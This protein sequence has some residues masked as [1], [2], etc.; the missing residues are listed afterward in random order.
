MQPDGSIIFS[1][2]PLPLGGTRVPFVLQSSQSQSHPV[3]A[4]LSNTST[5]PQ[6][7][8]YAIAPFY[9]P[10]STSIPSIPAE[11]SYRLPPSHPY[12]NSFAQHL[13]A[14]FT[15]RTVSIGQPLQR[16]VSEP[17]TFESLDT[18]LHYKDTISIDPTIAAVPN[19][20]S[21]PPAAPVAMPPSN[22]GLPNILSSS[23]HYQ[24]TLTDHPSMTPSS[25]W[26]SDIY[27]HEQLNL[28]QNAA[29]EHWVSSSVYP[30]L[31]PKLNWS[32]H[33][34]FGARP[35][36]R[37]ASG[38]LLPLTQEVSSHPPL[39]QSHAKTFSHPTDT[40]QLGGPVVSEHIV[41]P[42]AYSSQTD[43]YQ[44]PNST[45]VPHGFEYH[46][47]TTN[48]AVNNSAENFADELHG[49]L[50]GDLPAQDEV[51]HFFNRFDPSS[52]SK[53]TS[54]SR[55]QSPTLSQ[56]DDE[57]GKGL[58]PWDGYPDGEIDLNFTWAQ[59][60][61]LNKLGTHWAT[62][63]SGDPGSG[64]RRAITWK[65]GYKNS[66]FCKGV[67]FCIKCGRIVRPK[68]ED[69]SIRSQ[70]LV[71]CQG[72]KCGG[73]LMHISC[74][75]RQ[76]IWKWAGGVKFTHRGS[77]SHRKPWPIHL[78]THERTRWEKIVHEHP[79]ATPAQLMVGLANLTGKT[80]PVHKISAVFHSIERVGYERRKELTKHS[81]SGG[82][83]FIDNLRQFD[84]RYPNF[85]VYDIFRPVCVIS[86]QTPWMREHLV[87]DLDPDEEGPLKGIVSDAA[88]KFLRSSK[89]S[90]SVLMSSS[91]YLP[92]VEQWMPGLISYMNG[93]KFVVDR[94]I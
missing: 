94:R 44:V 20:V 64:T 39:R 4:G 61:R 48:D 71:P 82:E 79:D 3:Q 25:A 41:Q 62:K 24:N 14:P 53:S 33:P 30:L 7:L 54:R 55:E 40:Q 73:K 80:E 86:V 72:Y 17:P 5:N 89:Y 29:S 1:N 2:T 8:P 13:Q 59:Y 23:V 78:L 70:E 18:T 84:E 11:I 43:Q 76:Y 90:N 31:P 75:A 58:P 26:Q 46:D 50:I 56:V 9:E 87:N 36:S 51:T 6:F 83:S 34:K 10:M 42:Q 65:Q 38:Q 68:S 32:T 77:H 92:E 88:H 37:A 21:V 49:M 35:P 85:I 74:S 66:R 93:V 12:A 22:T 57:P 52:S 69:A 19:S 16:S 47:D 15:A 67:I 60:H 28:T 91:V 81:L 63:T 27:R 45:K